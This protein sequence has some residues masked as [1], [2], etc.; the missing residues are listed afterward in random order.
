MITFTLT[1]EMIDEADKVTQQ[2]CDD[3]KRLGRNLGRSAT[4]GELLA[5]NLLGTRCE[6][7]GKSVFKAEIWNAFI[8]DLTNYSL[9]DLIAAGIEID[10]KG[11]AEDK[12]G[13]CTP[14][15]K[16]SGSPANIPNDCAYVLI[17]GEF[18]PEYHVIGWL[19]G[20]ELAQH[21]NLMWPH[22]P[23]YWCNKLH[24]PQRLC[25]GL[26]KL[27]AENAKRICPQD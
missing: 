12:R 18:H 24:D 3:A 27:R 11:V 10:I 25:D 16:P 26:E 23:A 14:A 17:S 19:W 21:K 6:R 5:T 20:R 15:F 7:V 22:R 1:Q 8:P 2:R 9:P 4:D 13:L